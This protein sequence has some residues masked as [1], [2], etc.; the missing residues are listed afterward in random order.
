[1]T[2]VAAVKTYRYLRITMVGAVVLLGVSI[3]IERSNVDCWQTSVS[4]YY[5]T[6]VR[7]IF[8]G[9][10]LAIGLA[11]TVHVARIRARAASSKPSQVGD[12]RH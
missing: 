10:L 11:V 12:S 8:V 9:M 2:D 5:Y 4:A 7:A 6:P 3:V 1:M